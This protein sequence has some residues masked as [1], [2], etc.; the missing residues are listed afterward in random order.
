MTDSVVLGAAEPAE[1]GSTPASGLRIAVV[2]P[3]VD[4]Q[5]GTE[6]ALIET[7]ERLAAVY[8]CELHLYAQHAEDIPIAPACGPGRTVWHRIS[9]LPGPHLLNFVWWYAANRL[10][11]WFN[12]R[13]QRSKFD[14]V[15]TA[16]INCAD[17]DLIVVHIVF[18]EF[19]RLVRHELR[20]RNAPVKAW[21]RLLHRIL[22]YRLIMMLERRI[23]PAQRS[24]LA[25]VSK[26]T[27]S[28]MEVH[29]AR[30]DVTPIPNGV[31]LARFNPAERV[32]RRATSRRALRLA[33]QDFVVLLVGND[34]KKK[35][36]DT[37]VQAVALCRL[38]AFRLVV[39]GR[40]DRTPYLAAV[41]KLGLE[42]RV[43]FHE[44]LAD[45]AHFYAAADIYAGPS[46]H[47][48]FSL[49][50][51]E[52]MALGLPAITSARAGVSDLVSD[53]V[54]GF[55]LRDAT[56]ATTLAGLLQRLY[57][58]PNLR[59][60]VGRNAAE[61]ARQYTWDRHA[62][63]VWKLVQEAQARKVAGKAQR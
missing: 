57:A 49:P 50:V 31:D 3:F 22:Y 8:G 14:V 44:P 33:E 6:R 19:Y 56:D 60:T 51:L 45:P 40:D 13:F 29:F 42:N 59:E 11:R 63:E 24:L 58:D 15:M 23:Y 39:V 38:P 9:A 55:V 21:P 4:K 43:Q 18:S 17:A 37:L 48:A 30:G 25:A 36:L 62:A 34:W 7:M 16:G 52:A 26:L 61:T 46:L 2:S 20:L 27:A 47:D 1:R 5:H 32:R 53:G 28:E 41:R 54:D 35:G 10:A 12:T